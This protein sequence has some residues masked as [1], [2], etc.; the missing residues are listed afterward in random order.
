MFSVCTVDGVAFP[1]PCRRSGLPVGDRGLV[2]SRESR[3]DAEESSKRGDNRLHR[4]E[5][6][7]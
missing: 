4:G 1:L 2:R 6:M 3:T 7:V 5:R